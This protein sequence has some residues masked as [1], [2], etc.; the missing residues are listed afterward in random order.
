MTMKHAAAAFL[1]L[2][3]ATARGQA[4]PRSGAEAAETLTKGHADKYAPK[5]D[6]S[7]VPPWRQTEFFGVKA[8]G[9][10]FI[11][12]VDCSGSMD[13]ADRLIRAKREIRRSVARL[14]WP[15]KFH[16]IFYN[17][18]PIP[19]PGGLPRPAD[20]RSKA[21]LDDWLRLIDAEGPTDPREA[22]SQ[23][24]ALNP[25]AVFLLTDGEYP[26]G[27]AQAIAAKNPKS[28]PIHCI[29]MAGNGA[30]SLRKIAADSGGE[31]VSRP[32]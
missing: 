10:T 28:V 5:V 30:R 21:G 24:L 19:L 22:M 32:R 7:T 9:Q 26:E 8:Q 13:Q 16:V 3:A 29:D 17:D 23:A 6:W 20:A 27:S 15:Q 25:D 14:R 4:A 31:Y 1:L 2:A 11:Y 12:V 18:A